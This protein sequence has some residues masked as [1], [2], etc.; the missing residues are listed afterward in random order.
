MQLVLAGIGASAS[1]V[2]ITACLDVLTYKNAI[3]NSL[4]F[5]LGFTLTLVSVGILILFLIKTG[6]SSISLPGQFKAYVDMGLGAICFALI[7]YVLK[8]RSRKNKNNQNVKKIKTMKL[9]NAFLFGVLFMVT[10]YSTWI[11]Y[12]A[13]LHIIGSA[14]LEFIDN[15]LSFLFL[16]FITLTTLLIPIFAY[17]I[18]PK[19][20][21]TA[22]SSIELWLKKHNK[23]VAVVV[24]ALFGFYLLSKGLKVL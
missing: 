20:A 10:N 3:K 1:P 6:Y 8:K 17:I 11:I 15:V 9:R 18:T 5:L 2:A 22:L 7:P 24:L 19:K 13:G 16:T 4:V 23:I 14:R 12:G 21:E